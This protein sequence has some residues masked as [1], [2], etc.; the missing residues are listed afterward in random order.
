VVF[1]LDFVVLSEFE[2][3]IGCG[4]FGCGELDDGCGGLVDDTSSKNVIMLMSIKDGYDSN[5]KYNVVNAD[6]DGIKNENKDKEEA[7]NNIM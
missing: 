1:L 4:G 6:N 7:L 3:V 2:G 5:Y